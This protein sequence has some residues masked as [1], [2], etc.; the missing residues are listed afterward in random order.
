MAPCLTL[1]GHYRNVREREMPVLTLSDSG[2]FGA[3]PLQPHFANVPAQALPGP[4]V[5][6]KLA[7]HSPKPQ[8]R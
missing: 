1:K 2:T 3:A 8:T 5:G 4:S 7:C 6:T